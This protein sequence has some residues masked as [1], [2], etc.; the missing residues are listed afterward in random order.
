MTADRF[1]EV[2]R[3]LLADYVGGALDGTPDQVVVDRLIAQ[4]PAWRAAH[5]ELVDASRLVQS[6]LAEWGSQAEPMP[7]GVADRIT[8]ALAAEP[9]PAAVPAMLAAPLADR[10]APEQLAPPVEI[11][12]ATGRTGTTR[13][14]GRR[15]RWQRYATPVAVAAA[16]A[17]LAGLGLQQLLGGGFTDDASTTAGSAPDSAGGVESAQQEGSPNTMMEPG[18]PATPRI[19]ASGTDYQ[20]ATLAPA[21]EAAVGRA[22]E[23]YTQQSPDDVVLQEEPT[24]SAALGRF[25]DQAALADCL[26]SVTAEHGTGALGV[27]V[28]DLARFEGAPAVVISFTDSSGADWIWVSGSRCGVPAAGADTR[29]STQV[30]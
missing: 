17:A 2:D 25:T 29:Y 11:T 22:G 4:R 26:A 15:R 23:D 27:G 12:S 16:A 13:R 6:M 10:A 7:Q 18:A 21:V 20:R 8:A 19:L 28:V 24:P 14:D 3:D 5:D 1:A 30:G 9:L